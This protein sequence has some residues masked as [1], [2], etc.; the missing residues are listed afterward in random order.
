MRGERPAHPIMPRRPISDKLEVSRAITARTAVAVGGVT[1]RTLPHSGRT[2]GDEERGCPAPTRRARGW[3]A[4]PSGGT[5]ASKLVA[6]AT[7]NHDH[8]IGGAR[9][10]IEGPFPDTPS[11]SPRPATGEHTPDDRR[12]GEPPS[13]NC[14][15]A[16][17]R[18]RA[19]CATWRDSTPSRRHPRRLQESEDMTIHQEIDALF[20]MPLGTD[21]ELEQ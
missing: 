4:G 13:S 12:G 3:P 8:A 21:E 14:C 5:F 16:L 11:A 9:R 7:I 1:I 20:A 2:S 15:A 18:G 10:N 6:V 19:G 17:A